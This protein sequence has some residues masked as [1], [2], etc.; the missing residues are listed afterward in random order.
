[1][2]K[3]YS[4][5]LREEFDAVLIERQDGD[6]VL[7]IVSHDSLEIIAHNHIPPELGFTYDYNIV[8][9]S[10]EHSVVTCTAADNTG[11]RIVIVGESLPA[12]LEGDIQMSYPTLMAAKRAFDR[13]IIR[14]LAL[15]EKYFSN[16]EIPTESTAGAEKAKETPTGIQ[17]AP[18]EDPVKESGPK[19]A[20]IE[21]HGGNKPQQAPE[22]N[23]EK[24]VSGGDVMM[25]AG[26]AKNKLT[27]AQAFEQNMS[28]VAW[29]RK[30]IKGTKPEYKETLDAI[31]AYMGAN[32]AAKEAYEKYV[33]EHPEHKI[34]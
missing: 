9:A 29:V 8:K 30:N 24:P 10:P 26:A 28:A 5:Y 11:R 12:T 33:G 21:N 13:A 7:Q 4:D 27:V 14:Y 32:P 31:E 34:A 19:P 18:V 23:S 15:S 17:S 20:P 25:K 16:L 3:I 6:R 22:N 2:G 1:M